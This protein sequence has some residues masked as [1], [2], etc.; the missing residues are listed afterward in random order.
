M[1]D[2]L[3]MMRVILNREKTLWQ[4]SFALSNKCNLRCRYCAL[5]PAGGEQFISLTHFLSALRSLFEHGYTINNLVLSHSGEV[6]RHPYFGLFL[7]YLAS[8]R[9]IL[10]IRTVSI[11]TNL[12]LL[13]YDMADC[14]LSSGVIDVIVCSIDGHNAESF[15]RLRPPAKFDIVK[16]NLA[17]LVALNK[18][19][20]SPVEI[21]I[22]NGTDVPSPVYAEEMNELF[23]MADRTIHYSF[24]DWGGQVGQ[25]SEVIPKRF[26]RLAFR[27]V[28]VMADGSVVKCCYDLNGRTAYGDL[29]DDT[30]HGILTS[31]RRKRDLLR[32]FFA[33][34]KSVQGCA[35]CTVENI[36]RNVGG[37]LV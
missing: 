21:V 27:N 14:I 32:M 11:N 9:C 28:V 31:G 17:D 36:P 34:R 1:R 10:D 12:T 13:D 5:N 30:L 37:L 22:N 2:F 8:Y 19:H 7:V 18:E 23:A 29:A 4:V 24:H 35:D 33:R 16:R 15:E 20:D 6:L 26:C 25:P 3:R